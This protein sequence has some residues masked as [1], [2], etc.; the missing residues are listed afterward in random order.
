MTQAKLSS[1]DVVGYGGFTG[2][3]DGTLVVEVGPAGSKVNAISIDSAGN[4]SFPKNYYGRLVE[5]YSTGTNG[6]TATSGAYNARVVN[7]INYESRAL[8]TASS[9]NIS[10]AESGTFEFRARAPARG[11]DR[12]KIRL[13]NTTLG[14]TIALGTSQSAASTAE[15]SSFAEGR[16]SYV[17]GQTL[18]LQHRV[19]TTN[20][21]IGWG[22][23][24]N[25]G[26]VEIYAV[27]EF[28]KVG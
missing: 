12:H 21:G 1:G 25:F 27:L 4:V 6:G 22:V 15:N 18:Q 14:T 17:A 9:G 20:A 10:F 3:N 19:E 5:Q 7:T 26:D 2:G 8:A 11:V 23:A 24:S 16:F 28:W 13:Q